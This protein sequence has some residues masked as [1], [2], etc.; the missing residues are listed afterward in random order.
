MEYLEAGSLSDILSETGTL[1][2]ESIAY[3]MRELITALAYL[4]AERKIHRDIKAGNMLVS[5]EGDIKLADFGVTGQLTESVNKRQTRVGTP[6]WM[7]PEVI[8]ETSYDSL[9]DVW[10]VGITAIE[11]A[12]GKPPYATKYHPMKAIFLIP[13]NPPPILEGQFSPIFKNFVSACLQK[14]P[15]SRYSASMLLT[16]PFLVN[17]PT[18]PPASLMQS[19]AVRINRKREENEIERILDQGSNSYSRISLRR[20]VDSGGWDFDLQTVRRHASSSCT[21]SVNSFQSLDDASA[22][23]LDMSACESIPDK[24]QIIQNLTSRSDMS[25]SNRTLSAISALNQ[26][27]SD[28]C[29]LLQSEEGNVESKDTPPDRK[30]LSRSTSIEHREVDSQ[31]IDDTEAFASVS[32]VL[33]RNSHIPTS[34]LFNDVID[35]VLNVVMKSANEMRGDSDET[36]RETKGI[37]RD[38]SRSLKALDKHTDGELTA[39][40]VS[41]IMGFML[42]EMESDDDNF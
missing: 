32:R 27:S 20:S 37:L 42:E 29:E 33:V 9:A 26:E 16:H 2:E 38:L 31:G 17:A 7:A 14:D 18:T 24:K 12:H 39:E 15:T 10:S 34:E 3:V 1:D 35:P 25:S 19:I 13:K 11:L 21:N 6:Y 30:T 4:H 8:T 22:I 40:F 36:R 23:H 28:E 41:T 5:G